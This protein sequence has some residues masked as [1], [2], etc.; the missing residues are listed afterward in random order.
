VDGLNSSGTTAN[1]EAQVVS[2]VGDLNSSGVSANDGSPSGDQNSPSAPANGEGSSGAQ[3]SSGAP[4]NGGAQSG[5][6]E[7]AGSSSRLASPRVAPSEGSIDSLVGSHQ[8][9]PLLPLNKLMRRTFFKLSLSSL[10]AKVFL[11]VSKML[12]KMVVLLATS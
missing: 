3:I 4:A 5:S 7:V 11:A 2:T 9:A 8:P 12:N 6:R 10:R 1:G